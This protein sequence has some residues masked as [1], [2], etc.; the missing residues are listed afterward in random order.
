M[1]KDST[2]MQR[3]LQLALKGEGYTRPNP[4]VGAVIV[5]NN[6]IIGEGYHRKYGGAHAE[7]NAVNSVKN[8]ALLSQSTL[9]VSLEPCSHYGKTPPCAEL[10]VSK[11]I[12]RVVVAVQDPNPHVAGNGIRLLREAGVEVTVG[13]LEEEARELNRFFF[14]NQLQHRPYIILKWAQSKDGFMDKKRTEDDALA[15][16][17]LSNSITQTMVHKFRAAIQGIMVGT[18]TAILDNPHLT[19]RK[20]HGNNPVRIVTDRNLRIPSDN[21]L[22]NE[23]APTFVFTEK[24]TREMTHKENIRYITIDFSSN[25]NQ[26]IMSYLYTE[27]I[28]SV[29]VEGG[30]KLL[31]SFIAEN[32][33]D[34]AFIEI[35][36][37]H[38]FSGTKAPDIQHIEPTAKKY[39]DSLQ[40][41]LKNKITRNFL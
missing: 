20:W 12:P 16:E 23:N 7:V 31:S 27:K 22:F 41:H 18:N 24:K 8:P 10:I 9:Y 5:H 34:E 19:V 4:M 36:E 30:A 33:W 40:I 6:V 1:A 11:K 17:I 39:L 28:Q 32:L 35:S 38:L 26:Q 37:K 21:A 15:P 25:I 2:Y 13:I 3:C 14:I 29:L